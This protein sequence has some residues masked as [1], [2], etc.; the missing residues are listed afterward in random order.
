MNLSGVLKTLVDDVRSTLDDTSPSEYRFS[1]IEIVRAMNLG[2]R[3]IARRTY[4]LLSDADV[5]I[6]TGGHS[7]DIGDEVLFIE[8]IELSYD[9]SVLKKRNKEW[10]DTNKPTWKTDTGLPVDFVEYKTNFRITPIPTSTYNGYTLTLTVARLP[11]SDLSESNTTPEV[12]Y[13]YYPDIVNYA[14]YI[15]KNKRDAD[16]FDPEGAVL[17]Y[18]AF[19][20]SVGA[21]TSGDVERV[22][23]EEPTG[24]RVMIWR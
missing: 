14:C 1:D 11:V 6:T 2:E 19:E 15:L 17:F 3:E 8:R 5:T 7:Y 21:R 18:A 23:K 24:M 10:L 12:H 22:I 16:T 9:G 20:N 13:K 4:D